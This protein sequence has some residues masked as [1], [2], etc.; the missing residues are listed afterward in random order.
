MEEHDKRQL[1]VVKSDPDAKPSDI[2]EETTRLDHNVFAPGASVYIVP[3]VDVLYHRIQ[4]YQFICDWRNLLYHAAENWWYAVRK[5]NRL[6]SKTN[7]STLTSNQS[8]YQ[9]ER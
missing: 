7:M 9:L 5:L 2:L 6:P 1:E 8:T 4:C 3:E